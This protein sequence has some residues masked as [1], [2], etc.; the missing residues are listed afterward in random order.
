MWVLFFLKIDQNSPVGEYSWWKW[1]R[2]RP[3]LHHTLWS[4]N[5]CS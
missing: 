3:C 1:N 4:V 5:F 2:Q